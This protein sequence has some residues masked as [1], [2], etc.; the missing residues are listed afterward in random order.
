M[1]LDSD[2]GIRR[3]RSP[4]S[5]A[6]PRQKPIPQRLARQITRFARAVRRDI[7]AIIRSTPNAA[8]LVE[9]F[10]GLLYA[11]AIGHGSAAARDD[12]LARIAAGAPLRSVATALGLPMWL[13]RMPPEAFTRDLDELPNAERFARRVPARMPVRE[14][15]A[16]DWLEAVRFAAR[17][18]NDDF[19]LWVARHRIQG[20]RGERCD[21]GERHALLAAYAWHSVNLGHAASDLVWS[22]WRPEI[23]PDTA[24]CAAKSWF[25]RLKLCASL[26]ASGRPLD[27][28]LVGGEYDGLTFVPL[29]TSRAVLDEARSM[30]NCADQY[31]TA[32]TENR[33]R[34]FS[35]RQNGHH[36]ATLEIVPHNREIGVLTI[37]QLKG[38]QNAPAKEQ[39]W[40]AAFRWLAAQPRLMQSPASSVRTGLD[41]ATWDRLLSPYRADRNGAPWL[42]DE[43]DEYAIGDLETGLTQL[44]RDAAIRSWLFL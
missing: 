44:A 40:R 12:A 22:R 17:A 10:P 39:V 5:P 24:I 15:D 29:I 21:R 9:V 20:R 28:W 32:L 13:R 2:P 26:E 33:C 11:I 42:P 6:K 4:S 36:E 16:A 34:L 25:N 14:S 37:G 7:R 31:A 30:N 41:R 8:D 27:P 3:R 38:R 35:I 18:A 43:P 1:T 23:S 19:A